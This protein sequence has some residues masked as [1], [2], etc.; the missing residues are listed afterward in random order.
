[1]K[2]QFSPLTILT[3]IL[4]VFNACQAPPPPPLE[5][6]PEYSAQVKDIIDAKNELI[7]EAYRTGDIKA[8]AEHFTQDCMQMPPNSDPI[9]GV[10]GYISS[11][12]QSVVFGTWD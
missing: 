5:S 7:T 3:G 11:W 1:M 10:A 4:I 2:I 8:A 12:E 6:G 9:N